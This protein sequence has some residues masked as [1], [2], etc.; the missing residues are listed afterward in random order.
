[1][2]RRVIPPHRRDPNDTHDTQY[3]R[4]DEPAPE[5]FRGPEGPRGPRGPRGEIGHGTRF[6]GRVGTPDD[7]PAT[8]N[9]GDMYLVNDPGGAP[10]YGLDAFGV[11]PYGTNLPAVYVWTDGGPWVNVGN[12]GDIQG[13]EGPPGPEGPEGPEGPPGPPG[14]Q[15]DPLQ[16]G[17][18]GTSSKA[19]RED[20]NHDTTY[21]PLSHTHTFPQITGQASPSQIPSIDAGKVGSGVLA[22]GRIP[23]LPGSK[24]VSGLIDALRIPGLDAGKI[25]SGVLNAARI[26]NLNA[27]KIT[28]GTL[29]VDRIPGLPASKVSS[30][31]L[32]VAR[33]PRMSLTQLFPANKRKTGA[34]VGLRVGPGN[35]HS[36]IA[37]ITSGNMYDTGWRMT[38]DET[39]AY[40][41]MHNRGWGWF[42]TAQMADI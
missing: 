12:L 26:P 19:A 41:M 15:G 16:L 35:S 25:V 17:G 10:E 20:H 38:T 7:L 37:M 18:T 8:G 30:G 31:T 9:D 32:A 33:I 23:D 36:L 29:G 42:P 27:S 40:V 6:A 1:M 34:N 28:A 14:P 4:R 13:I 24:I 5:Q 22:E 39:W 11:G 21:A 3:I 2:A